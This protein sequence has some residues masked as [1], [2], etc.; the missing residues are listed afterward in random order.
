MTD[1]I[2]KGLF[3]LQ[4][5]KYKQFQSEEYYINM[6]IAWYF[7]TALAKQ[8]AAVLPYFENKSLPKW[9]HNKAISKAVESYRIDGETK[10]YLK[11]LRIK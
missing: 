10:A 1:K 9:V 7:A 2:R 4:D 5:N 11:T 6:M 8:K 3:N